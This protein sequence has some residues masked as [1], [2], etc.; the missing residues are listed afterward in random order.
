MYP[1]GDMSS[2]AQFFVFT[3]VISFLGTMATLGFYVFFS[4]AY[5]NESKRAPMVDFVFTVIVAV[6]WL[7]ASAAWANGVIN[8]KYAVDPDKWIFEKGGLCEQKD[9]NYLYPDVTCTPEH[10]GEFKKAN[11]SIVSSNLK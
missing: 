9:G 3:G 2:D 10:S 5:A 7:S 4:D 11:V 8:M 1:S 6:F